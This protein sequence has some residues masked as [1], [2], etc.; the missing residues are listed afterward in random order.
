MA[1]MVDHEEVDRVTRE[2]AGQRAEEGA[3][4]ARAAGL[5][6]EARTSAQTSVV[7]TILNEADAIRASAILM[8]SRGLTGLKSLFLGSVSSGVIH[9][10]DRT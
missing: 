6:A 8:G 5:E 3:S 10:A 2:H 1:G 7:D 4:H 9:W